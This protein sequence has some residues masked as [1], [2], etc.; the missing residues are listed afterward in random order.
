MYMRGGIV[1]FAADAAPTATRNLA[2]GSQAHEYDFA[3]W[4]QAPA[5]SIGAAVRVAGTSYY[6]DA[7]EIAADSRNF[8]G[9]RRRLLTATL[10]R[11]PDN[12]HDANAVRVDAAGLPAGHLPR[13]DAPRFH[14]II[15]R[16]GKAGLLATCRAELTG[17]WDR[18]PGD[19]GTIGVDIHTSRRPSRW[20]GGGAF[21]SESPWHEEVVVAVEAAGNGLPR[22]PGRFVVT[23]EDASSGIAVLHGESIIGGILGRPD[24]AALVNR[25]RTAGLP[26]TAN[27]RVSTDGKLIVRVADQDAVTAAL[28][29][30]GC[31]DLRSIRVSAEPT[32]RWLCKRCG[33]TWTDSRYPPRRWY[34]ITDD[35][36]D[37]PHICPGCYS[38]AFTF[39]L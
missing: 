39:P 4:L 32:G 23:L 24:L 33:R 18:G 12:P 29:R 7:L 13:E 15:Q 22:M 14:A 34:E 26:A 9:T 20:T 30:Y 5:I 11:E 31:Q 38:Y 8:A 1:T 6:Q 27:A 28:N 16:L 25:V 3:T 21:L 19:R 2:R 17:G 36:V 10:I 35:T 37:S